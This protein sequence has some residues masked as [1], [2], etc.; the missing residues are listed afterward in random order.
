MIANALL[1]VAAGALCGIPLEE[2]A[3]SLNSIELSGGRL[4]RVMRRGVTLL[5]DTYNANPDSMVAALETLFSIP[6]SGRKIA[7]LGRMGELGSHAAESY[8]RVGKAAALTAET[9]VCV[10]PEAAA[11][12]DAALA[13]GLGDV[14]FTDDNSGAVALLAGLAR[15]GDLVLLK[16]SRSA[17]LEEI[18][19]QFH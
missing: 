16:A 8:E 14:R 5:D 17:R 11:I 19:Q 7:M 10:G 6:V 4:G 3:A 1:A 13:A 15:K 2:C 12:G 9:L 18:L